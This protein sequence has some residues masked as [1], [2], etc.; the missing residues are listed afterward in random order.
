MCQ[1]GIV[2]IMGNKIDKVLL[3]IMVHLQHEIILNRVDHSTMSIPM[4]AVRFK[5]DD[6]ITKI[7]ESRC[8]IWLTLV[9]RGTKLGS[10]H[11]FVR[12]PKR[13]HQI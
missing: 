11:S 4:A 9:R 3:S 2:D 12:T 13:P 6:L 10:D 1:I 5:T 8:K 7:L